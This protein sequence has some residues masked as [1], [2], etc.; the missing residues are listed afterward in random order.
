[1][2]DA[3]APHQEKGANLPRKPDTP[4]SGRPHGAT[5]PTP[6][7]TRSNSDAPRGEAKK[8]SLK[9][10]DE[11]SHLQQ[12]CTAMRGI[13][14]EQLR[15]VQQ[16]IGALREENVRL[17]A[18]EQAASAAA[19]SSECV[20]VSPRSKQWQRD[21]Q[22][23]RWNQ[24]SFEAWATS[25]NVAWL[26]V[27][28][29]RRA[30][31]A[32]RALGK[33]GDLPAEAV[34]RGAPP[35]NVELFAVAATALAANPADEDSAVTLSEMQDVVDS[36]PVDAEDNDLLFWDRI[37]VRRGAPTECLRVFLYYRVRTLLLGVVNDV[38][39]VVPELGTQSE[40]KMSK[41]PSQRRLTV[42]PPEIKDKGMSKLG[43]LDCKV[44]NAALVRAMA[45]RTSDW[46]RIRSMAKRIREPEYSLTLFFEDCV[47]GFPELS[48]FFLDKSAVPQSM[49]SGVS[50]EAEYQRTIGALFTV[51]WM[52]R[53]DTDGQSGL[54][55]GVDENWK[56]Q[57]P[58]A[59][60]PEVISK[61]FFTMTA[62]EKRASFVQ[63]MD[64]SMFSD[65]VKRAGCAK[66]SPGCTQ[67]IE[68]LLCFTAFHDIMKQTTLQPI[69]QLGHAPYRGFEAGVQIHDHDLALS[70][71][72]EHFP[73]LLPS[74]AGL[75]EEQKRGVLFAQG[76]MQLNHGWFV[77]AEA[78]PGVM[79]Q[80]FKQALTGDCGSQDIDLYF[81]HWITDLAGAEATPLGGAEKLVLRFPHTVLA[82]FLWSMPFL[83]KLAVTTETAL[84]EEYLEARWKVLMPSEP[85][86]PKN[87]TAIALMR[88]VVMAQAEDADMVVKAFNNLSESDQL[89]LIVELSRTGCEGQTFQR[90][91]VRG[92]PAFLVYYGPAL[93]QRNNS[94]IEGLESALHALCVVLRAARAIWPNNLKM[95]GNSVQITIAELKARPIEEVKSLKEKELGQ[96]VWVLERSNSNEGFV[97]LTRVGELNALFM[98]GN[99]FRVLDFGGAKEDKSGESAVSP[100]PKAMSRPVALPSHVDGTRSTKTVGGKRIVL[101]TDMSTECDDEC[102]ILWLVA[103]LNRKRFPS[104]VELVQTDS[105]VRFQWM[106]HIFSDKF[107]DGGEWEL[108]AGG[109]SFVAGKVTVN[110]YLAHSPNREPMVIKDMLMKAMDVPLKIE[111]KEGVTTAIHEPGTIGGEDYMKVPMGYA[112]S[113]IIAAGI[114]DVDESFFGRFTG[115]K[116]TYVVGTPGGINCI[117]PSWTNILAALHAV[118]PVLYLTPQFTRT[119]RFPRNYVIANNLWNETIKQ[120]VWDATLTFMACRPEIPPQFADCGLLLRLNA[121]N[122][123]FCKDWYQDVTNL[124]IEEATKN[125]NEDL[126]GWVRAYVDRNAGVNRRLGAAVYELMALGINCGYEALG[127]APSD[128]DAAGQPVSP[129][130]Q[131]CIRQKCRDALF[132]HVATCVLCTEVVLFKS[133]I[134]K[135]VDVDE[136]GFERL[137]PQCGYEDPTSSLAK[138]FGKADARALLRTLPLKRLSPAYDVVAAIC[139]DGCLDEGTDVDGGLG[140]L[141]DHA[142]DTMGLATLS[143][144]QRA[145]SSHPIFQ[146]LRQAGDGVYAVGPFR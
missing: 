25:A 6:Y 81:L 41:M 94:T 83:R 143:E 103:A 127:F 138:I 106:A 67:R 88:L 10:Q 124:R 26:K 74:Y 13:N 58:P 146:T 50:G 111:T 109:T 31:R 9:L 132:E 15:L 95:H 37:S 139:A 108:Q 130:A 78:P 60:D 42:I 21:A 4:P 46:D 119:I 48:L 142:D 40:R 39:K 65:L 43:I 90:Y 75:D 7:V 115:C 18:R 123:T 45:G 136:A 34:H 120:T 27:S 14:L 102:A 125:L 8:Q 54:C 2:S 131:A 79:L 61:S 38:E 23:P 68:A 87:N 85:S 32:S 5:R 126:K 70:Y 64:W 117:M 49:S 47:N 96:F 86:P 36:L 56:E 33:R 116:C 51:Y 99:P 84:V 3:T 134:N 80:K 91:A 55:Y 71:V 16:E 22:D 141:M 98:G 12:E 145:R 107:A 121:A 52:L 20:M 122:A 118:S 53:L 19:V 133:A 72:L 57:K 140:L 89:C 62:E 93:L 105:H 129:E 35:E 1:M 82:A 24:A 112:D 44:P 113:I 66:D 76:R 137:M 100:G 110:L 101:F 73:H 97:T 104:T 28:H 128:F 77:Q 144:E 69:V 59:A 11:I 114:P 17:R 135:K 63:T 29:L 30:C 92:G